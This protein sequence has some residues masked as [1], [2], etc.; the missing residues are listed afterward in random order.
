MD[1]K[2]IDLFAYPLIKLLSELHDCHV[3]K[4]P[5]GQ[6][7]NRGKERTFCE[8]YNA[9]LKRVRYNCVDR[10]PGFSD[11]EWGDLARQYKAGEM[12]LVIDGVAV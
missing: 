5:L 10:F 7:N 4:Y 6:I 9:P 2:T 3:C 12:K 8:K 1:R 11:Q